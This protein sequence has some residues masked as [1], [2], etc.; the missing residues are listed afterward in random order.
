MRLLSKGA[1]KSALCQRFSFQ[2]ASGL[3]GPKESFKFTHARILQSCGLDQRP[4][5]FCSVHQVCGTSG[6]GEGQP[7]IPMAVLAVSGYLELSC[8][9]ESFNRNPKR[10]EQTVLHPTVLM[11]ISNMV[12]VAVLPV[13][14]VVGQQP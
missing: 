9:P 5:A 7:W 6:V 12:D 11:G 4:A 13:M 3:L 8:P 10:L 14:A 1:R 2:D